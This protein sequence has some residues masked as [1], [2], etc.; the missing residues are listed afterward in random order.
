[1]AILAGVLLI[2]QPIYVLTQFLIARA[3]QRAV[4]LV[5]LAATVA[6]VVLSFLLAWLWG[7]WGVAASTLFTDLVVF[8][9][10]VPRIAAPAADATTGTLVRAIVRPVAPAALRGCCRPRRLARTWKPDTLSTLAVL[11]PIWVVPAAFA[12]WRFGLRRPAA[13]RLAA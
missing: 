1:M 10:I 4:A 3:R 6:N 7:T 8:A 12:I 5:S 2:H 9:Y 11:G 13:I